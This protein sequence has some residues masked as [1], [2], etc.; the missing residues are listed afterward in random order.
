M[1]WGP[2][3]GLGPDRLSPAAAVGRDRRKAVRPLAGSGPVVAPHLA[4]G[5][6]CGPDRPDSP[7]SGRLPHRY[8]NGRPWW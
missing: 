6:A 5:P 2:G 8:G 7:R 4:P 3:R 1:G